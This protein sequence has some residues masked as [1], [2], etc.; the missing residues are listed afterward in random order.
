MHDIYPAH[1]RKNPDGSKDVQSVAE[2]NSNTARYAGDCL[3]SIGLAP[4]ARVAGLVHDIG[5]NTEESRRYQ[6]DAADGKNVVRGSVIH[7]FQGCRLLLE[8][9]SVPEPTSYEDISREL[10][11]YAAGAHHGLFD[12]FGED[13]KSGFIKR[14]QKEDIGYK[15]AKTAFFEDIGGSDVFDAYFLAAHENLLPTLERIDDLALSSEI[16][17]FWFSLLS[18]L[19]LSSVIEG[20]RRDTAMF[21]NNEVFPGWP[22]DMRLIWNERLRFM[23]NKLSE[24]SP[25]KPIDAARREISEIC[26]TAAERPAGIYRL[27]VPTGGGKTLSA[28]RFALAHAKTHNKR[29]IIFTAPLLSILDQNAEILHKFIGREDMILEHHSNVIESDEKE[30]SLQNRELLMQSWD[31]PVIITT[32]VQL[33]NTMFDGKTSS[34]R[35]FW[36]LCDSVIVIDEVQTVPGKLLSLFN[37]AVD[38]LSRFCKTTFV[39]CSATQPCFEVLAKPLM[40]S[41]EEIVLF[42]EDLWRPF[43]RTKLNPVDATRLDSIPDLARSV[44]RDSNS[45]LIVCN[46]KDEAQK[47]FD[48]LRGESS[49]CCH[50]SAAMCMA[51]RKKVLSD[52]QA[53]LVLAKNDKRFK[54]VCVSTQVIEAGVDISFASVIR[55][56]AGMDSI[57]QAAGRCNRNGESKS[58]AP[59][60]IVPCADEDLSRLKEIQMAKSATMALLTDFRSTPEKYDNDLFSDKAINVY[61]RYLWKSVKEN[62]FDGPVAEYGTLFAL[63]SANPSFAND[64]VLDHDAFCL[65]QAF[66]TAGKAFH[67]FDDDTA[68]AVVPWEE[69]EQLIAEAASW[70]YA[71]SDSTF[72]EWLQRAKPYTVT[73]Y[74]YQRKALSQSGMTQIMGVNVLQPYQYDANTGVTF[75]YA[76]NSFLEV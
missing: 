67:V 47:M 56:C 28:L 36:A 23:E 31:S 25:D 60:Y 15:L 61:Y 63:L 45:L 44:L 53:A 51:H 42:R 21:M 3:Q 50:L 34:I 72:A 65:R 70:S 27:N 10:L 41:P 7:T 14:I 74:D 22:E 55:F 20:D 35:R 48:A 17:E 59:V 30:E 33:L 13:R 71:P 16:A 11:A 69:G 68:S 40:Q 5:K 46:K 43:V 29:R 75:R 24:F 76:D 18:R 39:L 38:F 6:I 64:S 49:F 54:V 9:H 32:L 1:I 62:Y 8:K 19:L 26:R 73:L 37:C 57:I 52:L 66:A 12:C 2:H 58:L 4:A